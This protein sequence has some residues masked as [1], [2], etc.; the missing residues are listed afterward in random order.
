M[1]TPQDN[2]IMCRTGAQTAMGQAL[3]RFWLPVMQLRGLPAPNGDPIRDW[4]SLVPH[5]R[6]VSGPARQQVN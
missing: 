5:P 3:R 1:L 4:R 2:E 6:I